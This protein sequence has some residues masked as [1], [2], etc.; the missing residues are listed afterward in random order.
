MNNVQLTLTL[1]TVLIKSHEHHK[2]FSMSKSEVLSNTLMKITFRLLY[3][4]DTFRQLF[5]HS[6][7][8][9]RY[10]LHAK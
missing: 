8:R 5:D 6:L 1:H 9:N 10:S 3:H 7:G 4:F 2:Y